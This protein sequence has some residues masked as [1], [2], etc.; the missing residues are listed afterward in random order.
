ML[1]IKNEV[2]V[3]SY[4]FF[5]PSNKNKNLDNF[6]WTGDK[7][8]LFTDEPPLNTTPIFL[9]VLTNTFHWVLSKIKI[10]YDKS[11]FSSKNNSSM[12]YWLKKA[13]SGISIK[14]KFWYLY[15]LGFKVVLIVSV[16]GYLSNSFA[17]SLSIK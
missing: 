13:W 2:F 7:T 9:K 3:L 5:H 15:L 16:E 6:I 17:G 8:C 4:D 1:F 10:L 14:L 11:E 12:K